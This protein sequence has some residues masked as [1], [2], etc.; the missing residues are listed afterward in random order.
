MT[1]STET[2]IYMA[3][4]LISNFVSL[5]F[6]DRFEEIKD[7]GQEAS[8]IQSEQ[9]FNLLREAEDT[10]WG[11]K[12][13]FKTIFSY[14]DFRERL[15][16][17]RA[18]DLR[19]YLEKMKA[20]E[21]NLLWPGLPKGIISTF[22]YGQIPIS[23]QAINEIFLQG[24]NDSFA[25]YLHQNPES[26]LF[27][28]FMASIGNGKENPFMYPLF[29]LIQEN[30]P[31]ISSLLNVP[32]RIANEKGQKNCSDLILKEIK[33]QKVSCFKGSPECLLSL[34]E[35]AC[36]DGENKSLS[37]LWP[38]AEVLFH[39]SPTI[40]STLIEAKK[41]LPPHLAYQASY[42][43]PEGLFGIQDNLNDAAYL[44]MLDLSTFYEFFPANGSE[45]QCVPLE[46]I[47]LDTEY[48]MV[49]TNCSGLWR[50][51]SDGPT[52]QFVS[53]NPYRFILL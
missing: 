2:L 33:G 19:P 18:G 8:D 36:L 47:E 48:Q 40:T 52:L 21:G 44:L 30:E 31:F 26:N 23:E 53:K 32:K 51:C 16:I 41:T 3:F 25:I 42:C 38:D 45:D 15:P 49:V 43:S 27:S 1:K 7:F 29:N 37:Q 5:F 4:D 13:A 17:Q 11:E 35:R 20:G 12:Y 24:F 6:K 46:D 34:L 22:G 28:G 39:R 50:Y 14:Q 10:E 9:L